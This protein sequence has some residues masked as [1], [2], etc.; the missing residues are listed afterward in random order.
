M[1]LHFFFWT[2]EKSSWHS[3]R[4]F[5]QLQLKHEP[6]EPSQQN[7]DNLC[8]LSEHHMPSLWSGGSCLTCMGVAWARIRHS[9]NF[10]H[11]VT[12]WTQFCINGALLCFPT[13]L[14]ARTG[15][16]C[17]RWD[18]F[19]RNTPIICRYFAVTLWTSR[20][21]L[22][23]LSGQGVWHAAPPSWNF[24]WTRCFAAG[25]PAWVSKNQQFSRERKL[26]DPHLKRDGWT[27]PLE[28]M[29]M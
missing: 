13:S 10:A 17:V 26:H 27:G 21:V 3:K 9:L 29:R 20:C 15:F 25:I 2:Q 19:K 1:Y 14:T 8:K 22:S 16:G 23:R 4:R 7:W 24:G 5:P 11:L 28:G 6:N 12:V 18:S